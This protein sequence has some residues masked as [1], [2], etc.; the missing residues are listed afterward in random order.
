MKNWL[1]AAG[2]NGA[3]AVLAGAFAA[4]ALGTRLDPRMLSAFSTGATYHLV[5][6]LALGVT[7]LAARGAAARRANIAAA[8]FLAGIILFS[9]SLYALAITGIVYFAYATP[10]GGIAFV[11]GWIMLAA[12]GLKMERS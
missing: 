5:H 6:A 12:A 1:F 4:H 11:A 10:A 8:L 2:I 9:G 7:A 3:L